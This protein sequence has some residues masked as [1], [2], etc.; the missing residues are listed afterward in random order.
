[1]VSSLARAAANAQNTSEIFLVL[2]TLQH[3][4]FP[5]SYHFVNDVVNVTSNGVEYIAWPFDLPFP[6]L[7]G[8]SL[9]TITLTIDN[10][11]QSIWNA[12]KGINTPI[13]VQ[14]SVVLRS[15]PD[16]VEVGPLHL[17]MRSTEVGLVAITGALNF[18]DMMNEPY[19]IESYT[20]KN[21]PGLF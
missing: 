15:Q 9:P 16:T 3:S 20:P 7:G 19:P 21:A 11:D 18:E 5:A 1:M 10:V 2:L 12:I 4:S 14:I 8:D 6:E 17:R 13:D